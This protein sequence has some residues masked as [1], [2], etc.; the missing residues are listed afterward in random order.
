VIGAMLGTALAL[1]LMQLFP[2]LPLMPGAY[3]LAGMASLV[4]AAT[5]APIT[6]ILLVFEISGDHEMILPLL[7]SVISAI[8]VRRII[9]R[10]TLYTAWLARTGRARDD[11]ERGYTGEWIRTPG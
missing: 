8:T 9:T 6:A 5:G 4:A 11:S 7:L 1:L 3:A 10:K 2:S